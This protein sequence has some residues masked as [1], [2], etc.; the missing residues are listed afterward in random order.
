M[1]KKPKKPLKRKGPAKVYK[2]TDKKLAA[3][4]HRPLQWLNKIL[5]ALIQVIESQIRHN[6]PLTP[7]TTNLIDLL[8]SYKKRAILE[9]FMG[10]FPQSDYYFVTYYRYL[11]NLN[12]KLL[13]AKLGA[14][15]RRGC[16]EDLEWARFHKEGIPRLFLDYMGIEFH[17]WYGGCYQLNKE[18]E[19]L[20]DAIDHETIDQNELRDKVLD[21]RIAYGDL[22]DATAGDDFWDS[23]GN[24]T[25]DIRDDFNNIKDRLDFLSDQVNSGDWNIENAEDRAKIKRILREVRIIKYRILRHLGDYGGR[26]LLDWYKKLYEMDI[27]IDNAIDLWKDG[28]MLPEWDPE[29]ARRRIRMAE[30]AK[31]GFLRLFPLYLGMSLNFFYN[32]LYLMDLHLDQAKGMLQAGQLREALR[33]LRHVR[34]HKHRIESVLEDV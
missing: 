10:Y 28:R 27:Q 6:A 19:R 3:S 20:E 25:D 31:L 29:E 13:S 23:P 12:R 15:N 30:R 16:Q 21:V 33:E 18:I 26:P 32:E 5:D 1:K 17:I 4:F 22:R 24:V 2:S 8:K 14:D 9:G 7:G 34:T 11:E